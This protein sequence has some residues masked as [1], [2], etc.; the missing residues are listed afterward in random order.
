MLNFNLVELIRLNFPKIL[1]NNTIVIRYI[2]FSF[3][4][5]TM[6]AAMQVTMQAKGALHFR[7]KAKSRSD[8]QE[9]FNL[10]NRDHFRKAILLPLADAGLLLLTLPDKPTSPKQQFYTA[11]GVL[12]KLEGEE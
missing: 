4:S 9:H 2:N 10:K 8:I 1:Q 6:H 12:N 3:I 11:E 5:T 7:Y